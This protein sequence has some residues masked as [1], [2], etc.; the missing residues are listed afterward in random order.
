MYLFHKNM[1]ESAIRIIYLKYIWTVTHPS[2]FD[3]N[4]IFQ[5]LENIF[6]CLKSQEL[7]ELFNFLEI[8]KVGADYFGLHICY[9]TSMFIDLRTS[10]LR[11]SG[12][13][14]LENCLLWYKL[15]S[16]WVLKAKFCIAIKT[17]SDQSKFVKPIIPL[18][19]PDSCPM[20]RQELACNNSCF[21][22]LFGGGC[23][24]VQF[25]YLPIR[26]IITYPMVEFLFF[27]DNLPQYLFSFIRN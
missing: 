18:E 8:I 22:L 13:L 14:L 11:V 7:K 26:S 17:K 15:R 20:L 3:N 1:F 2:N 27:Y 23:F 16:R 19:S 9:N 12:Y 24:F 21:G 6:Y 5:G 4:L 10:V 25:E